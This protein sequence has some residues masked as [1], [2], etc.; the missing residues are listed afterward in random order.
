MDWGINNSIRVRSS[1]LPP[2]FPY[3]SFFPNHGFQR[4]QICVARRRRDNVSRTFKIKHHYS[5]FR[6]KNKKI[7]LLYLRNNTVMNRKILEMLLKSKSPNN[8]KQTMELIDDLKRNS[9]K[10]NCYYSLVFTWWNE[11]FE[12]M[13]STQ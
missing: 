11:C 7:L 10:V 8:I 6:K 1:L 5:S 3:L 4:A 9:K 2:P 13:C 12:H